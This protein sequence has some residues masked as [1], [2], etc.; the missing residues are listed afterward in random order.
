MIYA[1]CVA[2]GDYSQDDADFR[3]SHFQFHMAQIENFPLSGTRLEYCR[4]FYPTD[5]VLLAGAPWPQIGGK[6]DVSLSGTRDAIV[7]ILVDRV[8]ALEADGILLDTPFEYVTGQETEA[9]LL[10]DAIRTAMPGKIVAANFGDLFTWLNTA[11]GVHTSLHDSY[12]YHFVQVALDV[13]PLQ[14]L[15]G[16]GPSAYAVRKSA[17]FA[18]V[19]AMN[20]AGVHIIVGLFD[21]GGVN[22]TIARDVVDEL[23]AYPNVIAY[24]A[25]SQISLGEGNLREEQWNEAYDEPSAAV[26]RGGSIFGRG[27]R[28]CTLMLYGHQMP[29]LVQ[30]YIVDSSVSGINPELMYVGQ[31]EPSIVRL[32]R[33]GYRLGLNDSDYDFE[34]RARLRGSTSA[35]ATGVA[36]LSFARSTEYGAPD[37]ALD[38][39]LSYT[40]TT[41]FATVSGEMLG[42]MRIIRKGDGAILFNDAFPMRRYPAI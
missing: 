8:A 9:F 33:N 11:P 40:Q 42:Q 7:Q 23:E 37:D 25:T 5:F 19:A 18:E 2:R 41:G 30:P 15:W 12:D 21:S 24:Y 4:P 34:F 14:A 29:T 13:D 26:V 22:G 36:E 6:I 38:P 27:A 20:L 35:F 17:M 1:D 28:T 31:T 32:I 10:L 39:V 16:G 3:N